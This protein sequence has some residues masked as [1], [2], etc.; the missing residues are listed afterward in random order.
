MKQKQNISE[1]QTNEDCVNMVNIKKPKPMKRG[2]R[3]DFQTPAEAIKVL[4]PFLNK[5]WTIWECACGKGNLHNAFSK[6]GFSVIATDIL[7]DID[8]S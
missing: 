2:S 3:D 6:I 1:N 7:D 8:K 4:L 5:N